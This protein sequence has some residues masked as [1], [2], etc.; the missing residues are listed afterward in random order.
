MDVRYCLIG[1]PSKPPSLIRASGL[2]SKYIQQNL[3]NVINLFLPIVTL[4][5]C[6][7]STHSEKNNLSIA[8]CPM[9]H[10]S[11]IF[12]SSLVLTLLYTFYKS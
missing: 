2:L 4:G 10:F 12:S 9:T 11:Y 6:Q 7:H 1:P 5:T 3:D 8:N